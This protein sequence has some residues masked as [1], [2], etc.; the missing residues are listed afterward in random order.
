MQ[1]KRKSWKEII[2]SRR[3]ENFV[4]RSEYLSIFSENFNSDVPTYLLFS[5]T[6]EGGVGKSTLLK[7]YGNIVSGPTVRGISIVCD[8]NH[9][10]PVDAM[11]YIAEKLSRFDIRHKEFNERYKAYRTHREEIES[12]PKAPR[13]A[14]NLVV[15]G[16]TEF[17]IKAARK[18]PGVGV[19]AEYVDEKE[20]SD[21]LS[22]GVSYLIDRFSNRDDVKLLRE[23]E[24]I[25]TPLFIDLL[26]LACEKH[27]VVLMFDVFERTCEALEPWLIECLNFQY[28]ECDT[29]ITF[30]I[31]GRDQID[32]HW[33]EF[34]SSICHVSLEPFTSDET[35]IYLANRGITDEILVNQIH[36]DTGG[37]PV[38]IE[39]LAGT[40]PRPSLPLPD[41]SKD[42]V[43]RFL[44][45]IPEED[46]R[47]VA[48][49]A[50]VPRQFNLDLLSACLG[51]NAEAQFLWLSSQSYIRT[52]K[53]RGWF[54][55]EKVR[56]LML[57]Y[58]HNTIPTDLEAAHRRLVNYFEEK[59]GQQS[60]NNETRYNKEWDRFEVEKI[61]HLLSEQPI[62]NLGRAVN[63]FLSTSK[64][65]CR[66]EDSIPL[67]FKQV[68]RELV[69][70]EVDKWSKTLNDFYSASESNEHGALISLANLLAQRNDLDEDAQYTLYAR[71]A[72]TY[73]SME[74]YNE[75]LIDFDR[76]IEFKRGCWAIVNRGLTY[77]IMG[78]YEKAV[79]DFKEVLKY[80]SDCKAAISYLVETL[81]N[82]E[83]YS[84]ALPYFHR[85][86]DLD[87]ENSKYIANR[88][89][90]YL[91][92]DQKYEALAD[93]DRAIEL[94]GNFH[95]AHEQRGIVLKFL[96]QYAEA[97]KSF[98]EAEKIDP[99]CSG[100]IAWRG[101]M[102]RRLECY[103]EAIRDLSLAIERNPND[104]F[105]RSRRAAVY[106]AIGDSVSAEPD[107][108]HFRQISP[109]TAS[110]LYNCAVVYSLCGQ[111]TT[112]IDLLRKA[113]EISS[114][115]RYYASTDD[116]F[117]QIK[118]I[119][120][121]QE[122]IVSG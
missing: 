29:Y 4:G 34:A 113:T 100:C 93:F 21:A 86:I 75:A 120:E 115:A 32:Q 33:T 42:A 3:R 19:F 82:M 63:A 28:G 64:C 9:L 121:F 96:E 51:S 74:L 38:L 17:A 46:R 72:K 112:A 105:A 26:N 30:V 7:Q 15:R 90:T 62:G 92:M 102:Y 114:I 57:R 35:C 98:T 10:S 12:D 78:E 122:L 99:T 97:V 108:T 111:S 118:N 79:S 24:N 65:N 40:N 43:K 91:S 69:S 54:Y 31:S 71:R 18:A 70:D 47:R 87:K 49:L 81:R 27:R 50:A 110:D 13:G 94:D 95:W 16:M 85:L 83:K 25:L 23:P 55:H 103:D 2:D 8:E 61:Y 48:L 5:V 22:Q 58:L 11:G 66:F 104:T 77:Q 36:E 68:S 101:E 106:L 73:S 89:D 20:A 80:N 59:Q 76:A 6:G 39:L 52:S 119:A 44:Q 67:A 14:V 109:E 37:L 45:W 107:I 1:T 53:A 60:S 117:D 84:E 41:I 56:E 88:G 116:L